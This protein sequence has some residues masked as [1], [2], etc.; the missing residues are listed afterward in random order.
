MPTCPS[1]NFPRPSALATSLGLAGPTTWKSLRTDPG[2][3]PRISLYLRLNP[4]ATYD[5]PCALRPHRH[6]RSNAIRRNP[7]TVRQRL[8]HRLTTSPQLRVNHEPLPDPASSTVE[9]SAT[10]PCDGRVRL[11]VELA[12]DCSRFLRT[13]TRVV[14]TVET[15]TGGTACDARRKARP[16]TMKWI[17]STAATGPGPGRARPRPSG[18]EHD[19]PTLCAESESHYTHSVRRTKSRTKSKSKS[20]LLHVY[21]TRSRPLQCK[22]TRSSPDQ[23]A[24]IPGV[25][26]EHAHPAFPVHFVLCLSISFDCDLHYILNLNQPSPLL[27]FLFYPTSRVVLEM[28]LKLK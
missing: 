27:V 6:R 14:P 19:A 1:Q 24:A 9:G 8:G 26:V 28:T 17:R 2:F 25:V 22:S 10:R 11:E 21:D 16:Q 23:P 13:D 12:S 3:P 5:A 15:S 4:T 20:S 7:H 18:H